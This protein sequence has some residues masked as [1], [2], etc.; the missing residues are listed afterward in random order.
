MFG[1]RKKEPQ[2]GVAAPWLWGVARGEERAGAVGAGVKTFGAISEKAVWI[3]IHLSSLVKP[4][5]RFHS[6]IQLI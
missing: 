6:K 4:V 1:P 3:E 2:A 5:I